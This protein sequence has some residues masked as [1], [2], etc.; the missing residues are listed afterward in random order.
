MVSC[1]PFGTSD[2]MQYYYY[3]I[4][5]PTERTSLLPHTLVSI[6]PW[7]VRFGSLTGSRQQQQGVASSPAARFSDSQPQTEGKLESK[8]CS[9]VGVSLA[10][11]MS[12]VNG[13]TGGELR[14]FL[15]ELW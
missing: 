4:R 2:L 5:H 14:W 15:A 8:F 12:M 9:L 6:L 11:P 13:S 3:S 7:W 10:L 1:P